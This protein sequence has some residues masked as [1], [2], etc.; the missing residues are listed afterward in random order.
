MLVTGGSDKLVKMWGYDEGHCYL[1]GKG[2]S[3]SITKVKIAPN[4]EKVVSVGN[5]GA[6]FIW[7]YEGLPED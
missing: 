2:H 7:N 3:G 4:M 5:E 6:I 1:E